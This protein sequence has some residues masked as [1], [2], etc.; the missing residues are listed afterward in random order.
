MVSG[1]SSAGATAS[2]IAQMQKIEENRKK[3]AE[4]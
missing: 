2:A 4:L 1:S 3:A